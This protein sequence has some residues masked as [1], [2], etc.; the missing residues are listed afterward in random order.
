MKEALSKVQIEVKFANVHN[1][2]LEQ[3]SRRSCLRIS[4]ITVNAVSK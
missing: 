3:Y 2:E 4:E 1:D